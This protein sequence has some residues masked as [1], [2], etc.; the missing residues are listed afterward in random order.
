MPR[1]IDYFQTPEPIAELMVRASALQRPRLVADFAAG[2]GGLLRAA[3]IRWPA[4]AVI[5]TDLARRHIDGI[6]RREPTWSAGRCDFLRTESRVRSPLLRPA[7]GRVD[8]VLLN[9]PFSC[10]GNARKAVEYSGTSYEVSVA[11]AF[12]MQSAA[13]LSPGGELICIVPESTLFSE[14]DS[15]GWAA[16]QAGHRVEVVHRCAA[17]TFSS[18]FAK[19]FVVRLTRGV[20]ASQAPARPTSAHGAEKVP[21]VIIRGAVPRHSVSTRRWRNWHRVVHSTDLKDGCVKDAG[22]STRERRREI[23]GPAVLL[24]RVG[25]PGVG[26]LCIL[27]SGHSVVPTDCVIGLQTATAS[28]AELLLTRLKGAWHRM[29]PLYRGTCAP[30]L[31]L[32]SLG[33]L[34]ASLGFQASIRQ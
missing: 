2:D 18:C 25:R 28:R 23:R 9:P 33:N 5:A 26:K 3:R 20:K 22:L 34:L 12:V 32:A 7:L 21:V 17:K 4:A 10:R 13:F 14:K 19:T 16:L 30:Y 8:A 24:P 1:D 15:A 29:E 11:L 6:R 27:R 31:T